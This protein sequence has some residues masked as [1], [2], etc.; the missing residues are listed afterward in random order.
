MVG[1]EPADSGEGD[2]T[3]IIAASLSSRGVVAFIDDASGRMTSDAWAVRA[4]ELA[5]AAGAARLQ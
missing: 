4:V 5:V 1:V 2:E 3:G